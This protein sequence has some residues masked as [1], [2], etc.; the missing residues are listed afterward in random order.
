[1]KKIKTLSYVLL[2][3]GIMV[4]TQNCKL[5]IGAAGEVVIVDETEDMDNTDQDNDTDSDSD[6]D[7]DDNDDSDSDETASGPAKLHMIGLHRG[8][9]SP[10]GAA[11]LVLGKGSV[12][13]VLSAYE[14]VKWVVNAVPGVKIERVLLLGYSEQTVSGLPSSTEIIDRSDRS[15]T[16]AHP[17]SM[18]AP[19]NYTVLN[20]IWTYYKN[21]EDLEEKGRLDMVRNGFEEEFCGVAR[22]DVLDLSAQEFKDF[23]A[24]A[25]EVSAFQTYINNRIYI[26]EIEEYMEAKL[27]TFQGAHTPAADK[28]FTIRNQN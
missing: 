8:Y 13:L 1:M 27:S 7:D 24:C 17:Y 3:L 23:Q 28:V 10:G 20:A 21:E 5:D 11:V 12:D 4:A 15:S 22:E 25:A 6:M 18:A 16:A 2:L 14:P 26:G 19:K 9:G